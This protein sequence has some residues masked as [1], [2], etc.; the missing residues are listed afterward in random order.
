M[1]KSTVSVSVHT[2]CLGTKH[3]DKPIILSL[4]GKNSKGTYVFL[5]AFITKEEAIELIKKLQDT[6]NT[7]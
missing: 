2:K 5:D 3:K 6:V 7:L 4:D 1:R